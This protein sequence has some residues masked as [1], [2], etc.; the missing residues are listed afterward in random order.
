MHRRPLFDDNSSHA[1]HTILPLREIMKNHANL[2]AGASCFECENHKDGFC[3]W[4]A[5]QC[6]LETPST[7]INSGGGSL[8]FSDR[9]WLGCSRQKM[10]QVFSALNALNETLISKLWIWDSLINII[11]TDMFA[12]V[13]PR[14]LSIERSGLSVFRIGAFANIGR[15]LRVLQLKNNILK[16]I[17]A[18]MFKDLDR[19]KILDLSGN[20]LSLITKDQLSSLKDLET[21]IISDNQLSYIE[22]GTFSALNNLKM[23]NLANNKLTNITRDTFA[24]LISLEHLN[25]QNNN[26]MDLD[27]NA[28]THMRNLKTLNLGN[29]HI[30]KVDIRG[31][32]SL[33]KL[34]LNN[35]SIQSLKNVSLRTLPNLSVL[36]LDRN[37][38]TQIFDGDLHSLGESVRLQSLS[39]AA[40]QIKNIEA[41]AFKPV[42]RLTK[43]SLQDNQISILTTN[44]GEA[45]ISFLHPLKKVTDLFLSN[46]RLS[47]I[48]D[49]D[50]SSLHSLKILAVDHNEIE[51][52]DVRAFV[53]LPLN[54]LY[55]NHNRLQFIDKGVLEMLPSDLD[56]ID[57]SGNPWQCICGEEW[58][59]DFLIP[60]GDK[61]ITDGSMG[62]IET[63]ICLDR[64]NEESEHSIW[65]TVIASILAAASLC[66]LAVIALMCSEWKF[67]LSK[68]LSSDRLRLIPDGG[69]SSSLPHDSCIEPLISSGSIQK[70][71]LVS[72][73]RSS[74]FDRSSNG[75]DTAANGIEKKRV[76]FNGI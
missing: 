1:I 26:I 13:R 38:I 71:F 47:R 45:K 15:R 50:L 66:M 33:E 48:S 57:I 46:N 67:K 58:I 16:K 3:E 18:A 65:I 35:N 23:L 11:P 32:K 69:S 8:D 36:N 55:L 76:R 2:P 10:P 62:C 19:L 34:F 40:N 42:H 75:W 17:D 61:V 7:S 56:V 51:K 37:A 44:E 24:N 43:L 29:N 60:F 53:E 59:N 41:R 21:L 28:F 5:C 20:K 27:W 39:M 6:Y 30:S 12:Q 64:I 73:F 70:P 4:A 31:L 72:S 54:R 14:I 52:I 63:K 22:N 25:L 49:A 9:I 68:T 74:D